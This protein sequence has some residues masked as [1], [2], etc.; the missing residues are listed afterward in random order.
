MASIR[1]LRANVTRKEALEQFSPTGPSG[2]LQDAL[3]GPLR[4]VA[5]FYVPFR[6]FEVEITNGGKRESTIFGLDAV[7]GS[8]DLYRFECPP[9]PAQLIEIETRNYAPPELDSAQASGLVSEK[10]RR[11]IFTRGFFRMRNLRIV[12]TPLAVELSIPYWVGFRGRE[13]RARITV[14]DA[15][16]RK[17]EGAKVRHLLQNWLS[18]QS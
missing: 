3:F 15:V 13:E 6:I 5:D 10:V 4:S 16:R 2:I 18:N 14:I 17:F 8:L 12:S 7:T 9:D 1:S 11:V